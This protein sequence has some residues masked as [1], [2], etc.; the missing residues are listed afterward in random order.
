MKD[1]N[2]NNTDR[3]GFL[4]TIATGAAAMGIAALA[5]PLGLSA[6]GAE[7]FKKTA[8][9]ADAWFGRIKGKHRIIFDVTEPHEILPFAWPR[10]FLLTNQATGTPEKDNTAVVVLRHSGIPYAFE[11]RLWEKYKF[12]EIFKI[13]DAATK[14]PSVKNPFW[15]P[16]P[17]QYKL[18]GIG[19]VDIGI[20]QLQASGVMFCVCDVAM[21]V[22][23]GAVGQ[24]TKMDPADIKKDWL[25]GVL[26]GIQVVP[27]GVW[28]VGRAQEHGCAYCFAG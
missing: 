19:S 26:P 27:S 7:H 2:I 8:E 1:V 6:E 5:A 3:R 11:D 4:G 16:A 15:K 17:D 21:T 9:D 14:A 20:D 10:V 28:A 22:Y 24:M 25:S 13:D 18:P 12:G 23:S